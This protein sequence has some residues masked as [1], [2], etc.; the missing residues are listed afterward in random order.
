M[1][2][3]HLVVMMM[4]MT[5]MYVQVTQNSLRSYIAVVPQDTVL[6]NNDILYVF[7]SV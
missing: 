5:M 2:G 4:M 3:C 7:Q 6:F 1:S